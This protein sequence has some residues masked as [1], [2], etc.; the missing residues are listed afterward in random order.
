MQPAVCFCGTIL[1]VTPTGRYPASLLYAAR[2]FLD[3][4]EN[5]RAAI[6]LGHSNF[7]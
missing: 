7:F 2:T 4:L 6:V 1:R 5:Q 3:M